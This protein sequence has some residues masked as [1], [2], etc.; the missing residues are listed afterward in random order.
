MTIDTE[1]PDRADGRTRARVAA[2]LARGQLPRWTPWA[3]LAGSLVVVGGARSPLPGSASACCVV[4]S[5]VVY[6]VATYVISRVV[7]GR[8]KATDRLVTTVVGSA[9]LIAMMP[10]V[11][12]VFTVVSNGIGRFDV[13]FFT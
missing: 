6:A 4:A 2:P 5:A 9:F 8:R 13:S 7:E 12:V 10:L 3:V 11:S 1:R